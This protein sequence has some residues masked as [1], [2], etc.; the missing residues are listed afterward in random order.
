MAHGPLINERQLASASFLRDLTS[1]LAMPEDVLM[2]IAESGGGSEGFRGSNLAQDL[3]RGWGTPLTEAVGALLIAEHLYRRKIDLNISIDDAV[4][5]LAI[6]ASD[7][8]PP[9][10]IDEKHREAIAAV[11]SFKRE[12]EVSLATSKAVVE[13]PHYVGAN[14]SWGVK[15]VPIS[16]GEVVQIPVLSFS[17]I[18]HDG[19]ENHHEMFL[20]MVDRDWE[21]FTGKIN[22]LSDSRGNAI[23]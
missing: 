7:M 5:Q 8:E 20:Q 6:V 3:R 17:I 22:A 11:L 19:A 12:Y 9:I 14:G 2:A 16:S 1:F 4:E 10:H 15:S 21:D 18:W 13:G 23:Q